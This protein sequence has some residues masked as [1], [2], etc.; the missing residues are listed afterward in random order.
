MEPTE[1]QW[2]PTTR[3]IVGISLAIFGVYIIYL[4]RSVL[5]ILILAALIAFLINPLVSF[6]ANKFRLPKGLALFI[7]YLIGITLILLTPLLLIPPIVNAINYFLNL[8]YPDLFSQAA[9]GIR[10]YLLF[11]KS[12]P[13]KIMGVNIIL[14]SI[15]DEILTMLNSSG[16]GLVIPE[17]PSVSTIITSSFYAFSHTSGVAVGMVSSVISGILGFFVMIISSIYLIKD[18]GQMHSSII[19]LIP[20]NSRHEFE[21]LVELLKK[22]WGSFF[23]GQITLMIIIGLIVWLGAWAIGLPGAISLGVIAGLMEIIPNIGPVIATI[24]AVLVA[25][26][27]GSTYLPVNNPVFALIVIGMYIIIQ[28]LE[29][30]LIVPNVMGESVHLHPIIIIVGVLVGATRWGILGALLAAP[31]IASAKIILLF[32][33]RKTIGE[34]PFQ[35]LQTTEPKKLPISKV[36]QFI[37]KTK[38][39]VIPD[40]ESVISAKSDNQDQQEQ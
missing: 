17:L 20:E 31:V 35:D 4:S 23:R 1:N 6:F 13:L 7:A 9:N 29:N 40:D 11:L 14:D 3:Y 38:N 19:S 24:P 2:K 26:I 28:L 39:K 16:Q 25:L 5:S 30:T 15:I 22:T 37:N 10:D 18:G 8:D 21:T 34:N 32:L 33:Y 36:W 27:Q 12:N